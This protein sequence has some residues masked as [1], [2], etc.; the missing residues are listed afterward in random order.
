MPRDEVRPGSDVV[1]Q[2]QHDLAGGGLDAMLPGRTGS[3]PAAGTDPA[4]PR[5]GGGKSV[6]QLVRAVIRA[7]HHHDQ[8]RSR[9]IGQ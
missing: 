3:T 9:G 1:V 2:E 8:L 4:H 7:V 5:V 6:D